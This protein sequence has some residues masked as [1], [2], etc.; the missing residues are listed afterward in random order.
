MQAAAVTRGGRGDISRASG[1]RGFTRHCA[2]A[3][4][5]R[6]DR[7]EGGQNARRSAV[8]GL[9]RRRTRGEVDGTPKTAKAGDMALSG[10]SSG[11]GA[12][13]RVVS[14]AQWEATV[15]RLCVTL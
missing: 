1:G 8:P 14:M 4:S 10:Q 12:G 3:R 5:G 9:E 11:G 6:I 2:S 15:V 7:L 13:A